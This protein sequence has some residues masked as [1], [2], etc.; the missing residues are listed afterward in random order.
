MTLTLS[1]YYAFIFSTVYAFIVEDLLPK[2]YCFSRKVAFEFSKPKI[3]CQN[4]SK[5]WFQ[6]DDME[7]LFC[8]TK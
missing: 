4:V 7:A 2:T 5:I 1:K 3:L 6:V 8:F